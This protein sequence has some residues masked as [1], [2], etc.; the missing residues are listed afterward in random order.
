[1]WKIEQIMFTMPSETR[2]VLIQVTFSQVQELHSKI[3]ETS[4]IA[5]KWVKILS[6][7]KYGISSKCDNHILIFTLSWSNYLSCNLIMNH[8]AFY[9]EMCQ[10]IINICIIFRSMLAVYICKLYYKVKGM[11]MYERQILKW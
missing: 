4:L 8:L 9:T 1:M 3:E 2:S 5:T 10:T 7:K 11:N 6:S